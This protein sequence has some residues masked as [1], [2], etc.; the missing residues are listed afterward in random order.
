MKTE[1][2]QTNGPEK[3]KLMTMHNILH[4]TDDIDCMKKRGRGLASSENCV[5]ALI[6]GLEDNNKK[7]KEKL[8]TA[9]NNGIDNR[10]I[11]LVNKQEEN[12]CKNIS[13]DKLVKLSASKH[14]HG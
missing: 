1:W 10:K 7:S 12:N 11:K 13:G 14:W 2:A 9:A 6:Q 8:I 3:R 4:P 5:D